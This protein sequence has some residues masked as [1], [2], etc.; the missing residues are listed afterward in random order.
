MMRKMIAVM[1]VV[2]CCLNA[3]HATEKKARFILDFRPASF[4]LS[5]D[6]EG[7][8]LRDAGNTK[9]ET[10]SDGFSWTPSVNAGVSLPLNTCEVT[11]TAGS[12]YLWNDGFSSSFWQADLSALFDLADGRFRIGPHVGVLGLGDAKWDPLTNDTGKGQVDLT[13]NTG[14]KGGL[15]I[16]AGGERVAFLAN[17]DFV[18]VR[19]DVTTRS[20]WI[21][22]DDQGKELTELDMSGVMVDLGLIIRF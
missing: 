21:A 2:M 5:P 8:T 3:T 19:Y 9:R 13:G 7:F 16:Q 20:G 22:Q 4:L 17:I 11:L 15:A 14:F 1:V 18:D 6:L 10:I 12:G